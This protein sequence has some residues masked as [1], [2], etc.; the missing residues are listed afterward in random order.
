MHTKEIKLLYSKIKREL[1]Q[2]KGKL[3]SHCYFLSK[4]NVLAL[5][6][7]YGDSRHPYTR[8]GF[9]LWAYASGY[10]NVNETNFYIIPFTGEGKEPY[11][12]FYGG[13][14][15]KKGQYDFFSITGVSDTEFGK[16]KVERYVVFTP[17][18]AIYLR[19]INK[20]IFSLEIS[21][22]ASKDIIVNLN[23]LNLSKKEVDVYLSNFINPLLAHTN[24]ES[25]EVKWFRKSAINPDGAILYCV[26]DVSREIHL[27]NYLVIK[28]DTDGEN[29]STS[30]RM[31]YTGDKNG[32]LSTSIC[33]KKGQ[34]EVE[35]KVSQFIDMAIYGDINKKHL[36][37]LEDF[38]VSLKMS[39]A[40]S[41]K[42]AKE[43]K[44]KPFSKKDN[45]NDFESLKSEYNKEFTNNKNRL[46]VDFKGLKNTNI[47][48]ETFNNFLY[49]VIGQVDYC[50]KAKNSSLMMLGIRDVAQML[51]AMCMWNPKFVKEKLLYVLD[52][53]Y[54]D[55]L[56]RVPRQAGSFNNEGIALVDSRQFIDQGQWL[57][58]TVYKYL[59]Y[60]A[61]YKFLDNKCGYVTF[62][63]KKHVKRSENKSTVFTH[64]VNIIDNLCSYIDEDTKC[65]R[66]LFGDWN[67][68]VDGLGRS[69]DP[70]KEFGNGV[71]VMASFHMYRN[72]YEFIKIA[73]LKG[74]DTSKYEKVRKELFEGL[75][76]H[77]IVKQN[78]ENRI[79]H[80]WGDNRSFYVGSFDDVDHK[81]RHSVTSNAFY[82]I[83]EYFKD[84]ESY[85]PDVIKAFEALDSKYGYKTFDE[86]FDRSNAGK[87]GRII[88]LPKG[89]AENA[90]TYIHASMFAFKALSMIKEI[91]LAYTQLLKLIPITHESISTSPFVM[92]N[93]YGYNLELG[94]DGQSMNDWYTGSSNTLLK[95]LVESF[96]GIE[97]LWE[98]K[99]S[100]SPNKLPVNEVNIDIT[101]KGRRIKYHQ[102]S[103]SNNSPVIK[104]N[105]KVLNQSVLDLNEIKEK[106]IVIEVNY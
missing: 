87:V 19:A 92:P 55:E 99:I 59:C 66:T 91:D 50:A 68:A 41:E 96:V 74:L 40:F 53:I 21:V 29:H 69:E 23:V 105:D 61:D 83:S 64:L 95:G 89:T 75:R 52:Y 45:Q 17:T 81:A 7:P 106:R 56:G 10:I 79:V 54:E 22:N 24:F 86:Y 97:P 67:D 5:P 25:E 76:K 70:N 35:K 103:K 12:A 39:H 15:N 104:V 60:T 73:K 31:L 18:S 65:L 57:I 43:L 36:Y 48:D 62:V 84:D 33:L 71:S 98:N 101:I 72:L 93:S 27:H 30:T 37:S 20:V 9:T 34:F 26:E 51:E 47:N 1:K 42:D 90:A 13:I 11:L 102:I 44:Q 77:A 82:I 28:R 38:N 63:D 16:E 49:Q 3:P 32:Q 100:I 8:D 46:V 78:G 88:N 80:G 2:E 85:I 58:T 94:I 14:L 4:D 6:N